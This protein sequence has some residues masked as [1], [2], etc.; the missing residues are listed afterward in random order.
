[1]WPWAAGWAAWPRA[2]GMREGDVAKG[3]GKGGVSL[4]KGLKALVEK[5]ADVLAVEEG[6]DEGD[7]H[8]WHLFS[9]DTISLVCQ[10]RGV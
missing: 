2:V 7:G 10:R 8:E 1:M 5:G 3:G 4:E 6:E 9:R